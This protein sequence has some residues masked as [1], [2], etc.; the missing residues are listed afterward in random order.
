MAGS[1]TD[2]GGGR[3]VEFKFRVDGPV[4][5]EAL[6]RA[7]G[8]QPSVPVLQT[9]HFFDTP[10]RRLAAGRHT[11]RL[12][13]EAGRFRLTAK[14]PVER[15]G[16]LTSRTE[17]EVEVPGAEA[18]AIVHGSRSPL[19]ALEV[20]ADPRARDFLKAMRGIVGRAPL[21]H[22]GA[23]QNERARLTVPL[24]IEGRTI[25]LTFEL[26]RTTFPGHQVHHEVEVEIAGVDAAAV[27]RA[28]HTFFQG[29]GVSWREAPS[30][31]S[32]FFAALAGR[33]I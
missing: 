29:A 13:E 27:E 5:F 21:R 26:D 3:E 11:L 7:A 8:A 10:D 23:F 22:L 4:A 25:P 19:S 24:T 15:T 12:R 17:E 14:G 32:R 33:P 16:T 1:L 2:T 9:N 28:L 30:K 18:E 6:A 20:R 31:A